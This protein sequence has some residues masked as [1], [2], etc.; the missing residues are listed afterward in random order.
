MENILVPL[1]V[2]ERKNILL[3]PYFRS[4]STLKSEGGGHIVVTAEL[5]IFFGALKNWQAIW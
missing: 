4:M 1:V 2:L 3:G 5:L